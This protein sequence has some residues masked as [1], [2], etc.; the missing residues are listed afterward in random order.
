M[1]GRQKIGKKQNKTERDGETGLTAAG[2]WR[3]RDMGRWDGMGR[4]R[5]GRG[6]KETRPKLRNGGSRGLILSLAAS[7][8][9]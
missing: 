3:R 2:V 9:E 1:N 4:G 5:E 7:A 6:R 8:Y